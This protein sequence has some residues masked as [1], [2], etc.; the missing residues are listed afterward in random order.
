MRVKFWGVR[1]SVAVSGGEFHRTG[2]N[3][4]CVEVTHEGH[5]LI[6]DGG[7]GLQALGRSLGAPVDATLLF[8]HVHWDHIQ[9]VPF[10]GPAYH[11]GSRI[12]FVGA[13]GVKDALAA[14]MRPPMFPVTLDAFRAQLAFWET[15]PHAPFE[16]GPFRVTSLQMP[17]PDGVVCYR[18]SAGGRTLVF[19]TDVEHGEALDPRLVAFSEGADLLVHDAQYTTAEYQ[20]AQ[21]PCRK[22][23]GHST[24]EQAV[25]AGRAAG[26]QR[27]A[28][29][30]HDPTRTDDSV[31]RIEETARALWP[32]AHPSRG[33]FAA[34]EG[35]S[36]VL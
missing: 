12:T 27:V 9:G 17:H 20:G 24:W 22:G 28:L 10:F 30:H 4:T 26:A 6:L 32:D 36:V 35:A 14:Q 15:A 13:Q 5:R 34:R 7:T 18:I 3:T 8:T 11:P 2:G 16:I 33:V 21:G 19:A 31:V 23:W 1:G 29:F 25:E